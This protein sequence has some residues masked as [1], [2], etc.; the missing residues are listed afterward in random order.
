MMSASSRSRKSRR[1][2]PEFFRDA[3]RPFTFQDTIFILPYALP[4]DACVVIKV[5]FWRQK[6]DGRLRT[7]TCVGFVTNLSVN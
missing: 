3:L 5:C 2:V 6:L 4:F 7:L 1:L